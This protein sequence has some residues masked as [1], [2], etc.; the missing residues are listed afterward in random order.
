MTT[1]A[2]KNLRRSL[3]FHLFL[4]RS[5]S[6]LQKKAHPDVS[7]RNPRAVPQCWRLTLE[8]PFSS[9]PACET[10]TRP[11]STAT[12]NL[13]GSRRPLTVP[14][15]TAQ[16]ACWKLWCRIVVLPSCV[17]ISNIINICELSVFT[18]KMAIIKGEL[19]FLRKA[20]VC[21]QAWLCPI[22]GP[23]DP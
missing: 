11:P 8:G 6:H 17:T 9:H 21:V 22:P 23:G 19:L 20:E 1:L 15:H 7:A 4:T 18:C 2:S 3:I 10:Q 14:E 5:V 12:P 16:S 13:K